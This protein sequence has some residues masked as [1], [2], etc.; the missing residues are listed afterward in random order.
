M[1][2][3][4]RED[5]PSEPEFPADLRKLGYF[6]NDKDQIRKI[7]DSKQEF[8][9]KI[10]KNERVNEVQREAMNECIRKIVTSRLCELNFATLHLPLA[11]KLTEPHVPI[12][13]SSN[14][15]TATRIIVVFGEPIQDLGIWAYRSVG[16]DGVNAGSAVSFAKAVL[17]PKSKQEGT[18][19]NSDKKEGNTALI[20]ANT[21]QLLWHCGARRPMT[22]ASWIAYPRPSAVD[23]QLMMTRRNIIPNNGNWFEHIASVFQE[24]LADRGRLVRE[25]ATIDIVGVAD[26]GQGVIRYLADHW[27]AW[28][29]YIS[30]IA[31]TNPLHSIDVELA[32]TDETSASFLAFVSSRCRAYVISDEPQGFLVPGARRHGCNCYS[33]GER[34]HIECIMPRAW[35]HILEWLNLAHANQTMYEAQL[36]MK[37]VTGSDS[38]YSEALYSDGS[39][40]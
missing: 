10:S 6:I 20:L 23:P 4:R 8:Q 15:S 12:M 14:L 18:N 22:L 28:R 19:G 11:A 24:I 38:D 26:G 9:Y 27:E 7:S 29:P 30:A 34:Q 5:L 2:V 17:H 32:V 31:L 25:D 39:Q 3:Y 35:E 13:V 36:E 1:F 37:E 33:S 40:E 21:G 16:K